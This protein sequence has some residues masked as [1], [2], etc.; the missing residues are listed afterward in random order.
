MELHIPGCDRCCPARASSSARSGDRDSGVLREQGV[1][2][3]CGGRW[4][5]QGG[6]KFVFFF[7]KRGGARREAGIIFLVQFLGYGRLCDLAATSSTSSS[8][9]TC[10]DSVHRQ[11]VDFP[12][13]RQ[14]RVPTV[15]TVQPTAE[16]LQVLFW[17]VE[18]PQFLFIDR[19]R[20][21]RCEQRQVPTGFPVPGHSCWPA[22]V[23][24]R[25]V[26]EG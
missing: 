25:Q 1:L 7:F 13:M 12:V 16:F 11:S 3:V 21:S 2:G 23:V 9:L 4:R 18:V 17:G 26:L 20:S 22:R 24:Q 10:P 15:Q 8:S 6:W 19:V 5:R 14:R